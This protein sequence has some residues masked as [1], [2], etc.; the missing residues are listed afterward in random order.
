MGKYGGATWHGLVNGDPPE[1]GNSAGNRGRGGRRGALEDERRPREGQRER[2][3]GPQANTSHCPQVRQ[4][5]P[6]SETSQQRVLK[7]EKASE[8]ET[9]QGH[10]T[11]PHLG[12]ATPGKCPST[13][14]QGAPPAP[15]RPHQPAL[16]GRAGGLQV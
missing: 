9:K 11:E 3:Q 5:L 1:K 8:P 14:L 4:P 6:G 2:S 15:P 7:S 13:G 12:T 16:C 10:R